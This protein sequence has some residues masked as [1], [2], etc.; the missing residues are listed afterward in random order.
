MK[1]RP[2][3]FDFI[4]A[5]RNT[6][7]LCVPER[8][9]DPF[10]ST[11]IDYTLLTQP[12]DD[13]TRTRMRIGKLQVFPPR[14]V[15]PGDIGMQE[16]DG[17]GAQA[18]RY[19]DF[20]RRHA[21]AIRL[22]RY[23]YRLRREEYREQLID[24]PLAEVTERAEREFRH[25]ANPRAAL[26]VGVDEPWDVCILHLFMR[27]VQNSVPKALEEF[28][29]RA[30]AAANRSLPNAMIAEIEQAFAEAER[31]AAK[32]KPLGRLLKDKGVF[33][34]YQDRFFALIK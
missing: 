17:F 19:L 12:M 18:G 29:T 2:N 23:S 30:H 4:Y 27:M 11:T 5:V 32:I 25:Q 9:L 22:L 31:D 33:D 28:E 10:E 13:P 20:L 21:A 7:L 24:A 8:L 26:V 1:R 34:R 15:S 14:L 6:K 3:S 16:L